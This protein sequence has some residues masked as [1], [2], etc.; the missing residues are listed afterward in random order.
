[1]D[2]MAVAVFA[3]P[4]RYVTKI[5]DS[6][7]IPMRVRRTAM[8]RTAARMDAMEVVDSVMPE[9]HAPRLDNVFRQ[10]RGAPTRAVARAAARV[11]ARMPRAPVVTASV[12]REAAKIGRPALSSNTEIASKTRDWP[13]PRMGVSIPQVAVVRK[14][15][16]ALFHQG[17][18]RITHRFGCLV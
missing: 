14:P 16:V 5:R 9:T 17:R 2:V 15:A 13:T 18:D 6:V 10:I 7:S 8:A 11:E 12:I 1:M 4:Q 3:V